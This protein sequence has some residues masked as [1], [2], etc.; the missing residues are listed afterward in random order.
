MAFVACI[1]L[2][3]IIFAAVLSCLDILRD[4]IET[5]YKVYWTKQ[6]VCVFCWWVL[7]PG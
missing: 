7:K 6:F 1:R 5:T 3:N 4:V 2:T